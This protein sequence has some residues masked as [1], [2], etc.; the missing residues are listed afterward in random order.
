MEEW[1]LQ[2]KGKNFVKIDESMNYCP[3]TKVWLT[4]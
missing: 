2:H 4:N 1:L 3:Q